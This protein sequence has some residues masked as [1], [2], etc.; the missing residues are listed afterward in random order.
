MFKPKNS[1]IKKDAL[2]RPFFINL[3]FQTIHQILTGLE[4]FS[5]LAYRLVLLSLLGDYGLH[6]SQSAFRKLVWIL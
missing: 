3:N 5:S 1:S 2:Q 6:Y 4:S